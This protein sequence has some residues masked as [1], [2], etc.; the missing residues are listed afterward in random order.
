MDLQDGN[1]KLNPDMIINRRVTYILCQLKLCRI[2]VRSTDMTHIA[3]T[4]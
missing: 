1:S 3:T 4:N 2:Y